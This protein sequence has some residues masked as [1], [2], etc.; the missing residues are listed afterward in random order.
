MTCTYIYL[1]FTFSQTNQTA[2]LYPP[3]CYMYNKQIQQNA[4]WHSIYFVRII[5]K[6]AFSG[7]NEIK[8][9]K[10]VYTMQLEN[11]NN[12]ALQSVSNRSIMIVFAQLQTNEQ[13]SP[14]LN[15]FPCILIIKKIRLFVFKNDRS[16]FI[17]AYLG[18]VRTPAST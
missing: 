5:N 8:N 15:I 1:L 12:L 17:R 10:A 13:G 14:I 2:V 3:I 11:E 9:R 16:V 4:S 7:R 18:Q 6:P